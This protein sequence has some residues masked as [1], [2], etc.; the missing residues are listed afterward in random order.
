MKR[1][2]TSLSRL[3]LWR[4]SIDRHRKKSLQHLTLI[5]RVNI[6]RHPNRPTFL[7]HIHNITDKVWSLSSKA[8]LS[9]I[10]DKFLFF[11]IL[12]TLCSCFSLW[13][14]METERG[15]MTLQL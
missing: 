5:Q 9:C 8:F 6:G 2:W 14:F 1:G 12:G 11:Y 15:M 7:D 4:T 10:D 13:S 3:L